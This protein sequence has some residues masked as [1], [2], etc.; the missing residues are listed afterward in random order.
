MPTNPHGRPPGRRDGTRPPEGRSVPAPGSSKHAFLLEHSIPAARRQVA[1]AR[2]AGVTDL[3]VVDRVLTYAEEQATRILAQQATRYESAPN[4][5]LRV[6]LAFAEHVRAQVEAEKAE[7][8]GTNEVPWS[9]SKR[10]NISLEEFL[11]G[12]WTPPE[13]QRAPR[14]S[15]I[16]MTG[17]NV[18][19]PQDLWDRAND[20]GKKPTAI[21][22]RGYKLTANSIAI[23]ALV[24][25]YG[26]PEDATTA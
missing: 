7:A 13:P 6:P 8:E 25:A 17:L 4:K 19:V 21:E 26:Q 11:D 24:E 22:Q 16:P 9:L 15:N 10:V 3:D 18:R 1:A 14:G 2:K 20:L 23:A 12:D 5:N